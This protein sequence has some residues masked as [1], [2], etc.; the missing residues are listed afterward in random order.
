MLAAVSKD[1]NWIGGVK[2]ST[3]AMLIMV[4]S[5]DITGWAKSMHS[6]IDTKL[7]LAMKLI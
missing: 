2:H 3:H 4:Y 1:S 5:G 7:D 6:Q